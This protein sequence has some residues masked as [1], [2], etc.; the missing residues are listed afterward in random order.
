MVAQLV[1]RQTVILNVAGSNP[2]HHLKRHSAVFLSAHAGHKEFQMS[3]RKTYAQLATPTPAPQTVQTQPDQV[4]ND[5]GGYVYKADDWTRLIR[6]LILG[7]ES[8]TYYA[9]AEKLTQ[10]SQALIIGCLKA[11]GIR[12]VDSAV[13]VSQQ[14]LAPKNDAAIWVMSLACS[15]QFASA[16]VVKY[17]LTRMK[18]V[19]RTLNMLYQFCDAVQTTRGWGRGLRNAVAGWFV[20]M[21]AHG[22][23]YQVVKYRQRNGW[24]AADVLRLAHPTI[25]DG[26]LNAIFRWLVRKPDEQKGDTRTVKRASKSGTRTNEYILVQPLPDLIQ[27]FE[28]AQQAKSAAEIIP[29]IEKYELTW[30]MIPN[31]FLK[32][33]NVWDALIQHMPYTALM[34]NLAN[35]TRAGCFKDSATTTFVVDRLTDEKAITKTRVHPIAILAAQMT[36]EQGKSQ[37]GDN[38][39]TPNRRISDALSDAFPKAFKSVEPTHKNVLVAVDSS[40]SMREAV[41]G[42]PYLN[43]SQ[44]AGA[45]ALME[46][47]VEPDATLIAFNDALYPL[48]LSKRD[49]L[50]TAMRK[51]QETPNGGTDCGLVMNYAMREKTITYDAIIVLTDDQTWAGQRHFQ[52]KTDEYRKTRNKDM[53]LIICSMAVNEFTIADNADLQTLRIAG[54]DTSCPQLISSF[55]AGKF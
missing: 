10:E 7:T 41:N 2:V 44:A 50:A 6:F 18:Y 45:L 49:S 8:G 53:R 35:M 30:E 28:L 13:V 1:E 14:G 38:E 25:H 27:G 55:I 26:E 31:Q 33:A 48:N 15:P 5:A 11:D 20:E 52:V 22:S 12:V 46:I 51:V 37:R 43:C 4:K 21:G 16:D 54:M 32:D 3:K 42:M 17:A 47:N 19:A 40:G 34:R 9:G 29:M 24:T 36:Y 39:W 23:A